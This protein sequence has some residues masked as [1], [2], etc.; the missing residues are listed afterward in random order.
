[1]FVQEKESLI[2]SLKR[3][4]GEAKQLLTTT[5]QHSSLA[6]S[7]QTQQQIAHLRSELKRARTALTALQEGQ[8]Q[9][10]QGHASPE[11]EVEGEEDV[12]RLQ[13]EL[14]LLHSSATMSAKDF[15]KVSVPV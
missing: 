2:S 11:R 5:T 6:L 7:P 1:L 8:G 14:R 12:E 3:E 13:A 15:V 4:L 10:G 9:E